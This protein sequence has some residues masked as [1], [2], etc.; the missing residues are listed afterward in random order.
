MYVCILIAFVCLILV[1]RSYRR[2]LS[3][4]NPLQPCEE[5]NEFMC[6]ILSFRYCGV[7]GGDC[8]PPLSHYWLRG[9]LPLHIF[10]FIRINCCFLLSH[11]IVIIS[12]FLLYCC[13]LLFRAVVVGAICLKYLKVKGH[14]C[15]KG[16]CFHKRRFVCLKVKMWIVLWKDSNKLGK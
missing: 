6:Y 14:K 8:C 2:G 5:I 1:Y 10:T 9:F 3:K 16:A 13:Y 4:P 11:I 7:G 15:R 12:F